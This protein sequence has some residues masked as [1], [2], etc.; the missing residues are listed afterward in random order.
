MKQNFECHKARTLRG[1]TICGTFKIALVMSI[2]KA[3]TNRVI[4]Q[5]RSRKSVVN[6]IKTGDG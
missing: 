4:S 2:V 1:K 5:K 3:A 6:K